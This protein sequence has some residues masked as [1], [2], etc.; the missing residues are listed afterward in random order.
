MASETGCRCC[1]WT[2]AGRAMKQSRSV[3]ATNSNCTAPSWLAPG[4]GAGMTDGVGTAAGL[5]EMPNAVLKA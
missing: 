2:A 5:S 3:C 4:R 1:C